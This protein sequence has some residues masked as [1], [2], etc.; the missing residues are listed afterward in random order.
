MLHPAIAV[1]P[2][3]AIA[4][5]ISSAVINPIMVALQTRRVF[6][7]NEEGRQSSGGLALDF[8]ASRHVPWSGTT[9]PSRRL[10]WRS[11]AY[12]MR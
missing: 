5:S 12:E 11:I 9:A 3:A 2:V 7:I 4:P 8:T 6:V 10:L 1:F